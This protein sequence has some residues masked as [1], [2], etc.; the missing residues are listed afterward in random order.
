MSPQTRK[1]GVNCRIGAF[2]R[3]MVKYLN[4]RKTDLY[5]SQLRYFPINMT[6]PIMT[7]YNEYSS[8]STMQDWHFHQ[9]H[10]KSCF[11]LTFEGACRRQFQS[12]IFFYLTFFLFLGVIDQ[13]HNKLALRLHKLPIQL[14]SLCSQTSFRLYITHIV[15]HIDLNLF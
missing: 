15:G 8:Q 6:C 4:A 12:R 10:R 2:G 5:G 3:K 14:I 13:T 11:F 7:L 9:N 1:N